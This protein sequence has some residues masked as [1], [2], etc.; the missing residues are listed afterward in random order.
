MVFTRVQNLE[1]CYVC[2]CLQVAFLLIT[3]HLLDV[4]MPA[5]FRN[6]NVPL[7]YVPVGREVVKCVLWTSAI[8]V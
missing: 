7:G 5:S 6:R 3:N 2:V 4:F 1:I 8:S